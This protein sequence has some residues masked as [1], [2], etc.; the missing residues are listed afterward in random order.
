MGMGYICP[1]LTPITV[2]TLRACIAPQ[3][4]NLEIQKIIRQELRKGE[5]AKNS[6]LLIKAS[7]LPA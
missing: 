7:T 6:E 5:G 1:E 4:D 2:E 3:E